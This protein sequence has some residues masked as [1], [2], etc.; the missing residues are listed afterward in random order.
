MCFTIRLCGV[1]CFVRFDCFAHMFIGRAVCLFYAH[2]GQLLPFLDVFVTLSFS[3]APVTPTA[4][5]FGIFVFHIFNFASG[6][7]VAFASV[8]DVMLQMFWWF[9]CMKACLGSIFVRLS[10]RTV[11]QSSLFLPVVQ[12]RRYPSLLSPWL[13]WRR[14]EELNAKELMKEGDEGQGGSTCCLSDGGDSDV[15]A[16]HQQ[17]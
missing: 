8:A 6:G 13:P 5:A 12:L 15:C 17:C 16:S 2:R 3:F 7:T 1:P 4:V 14:G 11:C 9:V 10:H